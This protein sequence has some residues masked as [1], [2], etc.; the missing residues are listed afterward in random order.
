[1]ECIN[2]KSKSDVEADG[3]YTGYMKCA[4]CGFLK[5]K[6]VEKYNVILPDDPMD[7]L[8]CESCQ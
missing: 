3:I 6:M 8:A 2:C 7:S 5:S 4:E 1:M